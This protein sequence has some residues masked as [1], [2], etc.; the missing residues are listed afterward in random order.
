M[1]L[2]ITHFKNGLWAEVKKPQF[3]ELLKT[4]SKATFT[5][6]TI[7]AAWR[8]SGCWPI[9]SEPPAGCPAPKRIDATYLDTPVKQKK[10]CEAALETI[11][12]VVEPAA[13][14]LVK[15]ALDFGEQKVVQYRIT[16]DFVPPP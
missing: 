12:N 10:L 14:E 16:P 8:K 11:E 4:S 5:S 3:C 2:S 6:E 15:A 7:I 1:R 13:Y 9:A